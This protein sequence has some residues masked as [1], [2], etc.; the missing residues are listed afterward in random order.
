MRIGIMG[1]HSLCAFETP[2]TLV[3]WR[4]S[5][6]L[7]Q[8]AKASLLMHGN[9]ATR[10]YYYLF[11]SLDTPTDLIEQWGRPHRG[12]AS[13]LYVDSHVSEMNT[14]LK[15]ARRSFAKSFTKQI[16]STFLAI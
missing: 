3:C 14:A 16:K 12:A 13:I 4:C 1:Q 10:S 8:A 11:V 7:L 9:G 15:V 2:S 5:L 6:R